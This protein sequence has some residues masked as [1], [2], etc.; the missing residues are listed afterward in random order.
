M[1]LSDPVAIA[2]VAAVAPTLTTLLTF[3]AARRSAIDRDTHRN[4]QLSD[5]KQT[6]V[7]QTEKLDRIETTNVKQSDQLQDI[8]AVGVEVKSNVNGNHHSMIEQIRALQAENGR[9]AQ[10]LAAMHQTLAANTVVAAS[11]AVPRVVIPEVVT[12]AA[13]PPQFTGEV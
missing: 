11:V 1:L 5:I 13:P 12:P 2:I 4:Q 9:F 7:V 6:S 3:M 8:K 10:T